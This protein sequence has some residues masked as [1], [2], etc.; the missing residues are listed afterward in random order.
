MFVFEVTRNRQVVV[1]HLYE[2]EFGKG[3]HVIEKVRFQIA[4]K[5]GASD[6]KRAHLYG[7]V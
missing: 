4:D 5:P 3:N 6:E 2:I 1:E 7:V